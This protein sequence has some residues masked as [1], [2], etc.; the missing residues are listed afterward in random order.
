V[1]LGVIAGRFAWRTYSERLGAV[2]EPV[3]AWVPIGIVIAG[4]L[5]VAGLCGLGVSWRRA[6]ASPAAALR[7]E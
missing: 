5:V 6:A 4:V 7:T 3:V 2:P 1:P